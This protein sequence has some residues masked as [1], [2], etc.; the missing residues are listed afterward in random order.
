M[1]PSTHRGLLRKPQP[2]VVPPTPTAGGAS[3]KAT[4]SSGGVAT[5][6]TGRGIKGDHALDSF[7]GAA[8]PANGGEG[9]KG[10]GAGKAKAAAGG[11]NG[12]GPAG[13][14]G[15]DAHWLGDEEGEEEEDGPPRDNAFL[16]YRCAA[17]CS[18][19]QGW[20]G[21]ARRGGVA[22]RGEK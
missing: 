17:Q 9:D 16:D 8:T 14:A 18:A 22:G 4:A 19:V 7:G 11:M 13:G 5:L 15:A 21:G 6:A 10:D 3:G 12:D 20:V 1:P 2:L